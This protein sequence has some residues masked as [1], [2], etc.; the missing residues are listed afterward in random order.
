[1]DKEDVLYIYSGLLFSHKKE[2][3]PA[4]CHNTEEPLEHYAKRGKSDRKR[5]ILWCY[6]SVESLK[7][8]TPRNREENSDYQGLGWGGYLGDV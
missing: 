6:L 8:H 5:Q 7:S 4:T 3:N 2:R 1:M